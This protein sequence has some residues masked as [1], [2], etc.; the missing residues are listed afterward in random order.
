MSPLFLGVSRED[1]GELLEQMEVVKVDTDD[2]ATEWMMHC[3]TFCIV[4]GDGV[5]DAC[6]RDTVM[7]L[8]GIAGRSVF[9]LNLPWEVVEVAVVAL[10]E[11]SKVT[12]DLSWLKGF[13]M[14][15]DG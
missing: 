9:K 10:P 7:G 13:S 12:T 2:A 6:G 8:F 4:D 11:W 3:S 1:A 14:N 15:Y 5:F